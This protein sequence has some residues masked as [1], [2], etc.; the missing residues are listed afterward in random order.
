MLA[1]SPAPCMILSTQVDNPAPNR[2]ITRPLLS[3]TKA[4]A[5]V[6]AVR[7]GTGSLP[8]RK[9]RARWRR[10]GAQVRALATIR[11][12]HKDARGAVCD[13]EGDGSGLLDCI[14]AHQR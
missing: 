9:P 14:G 13:A 12:R 4:V 2:R 6:S 10:R 3:R 7:V 11:G 5:N 8:R 1:S